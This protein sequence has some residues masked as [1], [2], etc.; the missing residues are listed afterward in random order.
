MVRSKL[1]RSKYWEGVDR[2]NGLGEILKR[3]SCQLHKLFR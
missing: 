2:N 1:V 3:E